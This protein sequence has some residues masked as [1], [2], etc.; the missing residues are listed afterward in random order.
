MEAIKNL[1]KN[2]TTPLAFTGNQCDLHDG[3]LVNMITYK[4][5]EFCPICEREKNIDDLSKQQTE[6]IR[7]AHASK[8]YLAF[9]KRSILTDKDL[10]K[11]SFS[12]YNTTH[13]EEVTNKDKAI[14]GYQRYKSGEVFN[15]WLTGMPGVG[16]SHLAM[17]ILRNLNEYGE[18]DKCCL[19]ISVD[20][21]LRKIRGTFDNKESIYTENYFVDL[22]STADFLVLDDLGAET[23]GTNSNK[24]AT[25]FTLRVL[26]AIANARQN[27]ATIITSNLS[28]PELVK[29]YDSK[30]VSRL[31]KDTYL[32]KFEET[33]DKRIKNIEF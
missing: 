25:D 18:K 23:G 24:T 7:Q 3:K 31:M 4:E 30:L 8:A 28:K 12:N 32:I 17:S 33:S 14:V 2:Q 29:M 21:M 27:K 6:K 16:K 13:P 22:L 26:Y 5:E 19:F 15:T 11:A 9:S 20:E 1:L 10:Y